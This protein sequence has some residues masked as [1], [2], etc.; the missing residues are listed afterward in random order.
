VTVGE[1]CVESMVVAGIAGVSA[2]TAI[3]ATEQTLPGVVDGYTVLLA[4][5]LAFLVRF[6]TLRDYAPKE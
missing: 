1:Q 5:A 2:L 3:A 4:T 6:A